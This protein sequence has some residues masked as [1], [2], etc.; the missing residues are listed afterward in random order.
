MAQ[1]D[2]MIGLVLGLARGGLIVLIVIACA[3]K[4]YDNPQVVTESRTYQFLQP[5]HEDVSSFVDFVSAR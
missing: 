2:R 1:S 5:F 3:V 4:W